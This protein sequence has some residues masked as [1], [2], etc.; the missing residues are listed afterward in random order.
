MRRV[1]LAFGAVLICI[2][3]TCS[4]RGED[5]SQNKSH[6]KNESLRGLL[7]SDCLLLPS[8]HQK[9]NSV[10][11]SFPLTLGQ[12]WKEVASV[13]IW[14]TMLETM[15]RRT[16]VRVRNRES[17]DPFW[18]KKIDL[19]IW[20]GRPKEGWIWVGEVWSTYLFNPWHDP[21]SHQIGAGACTGLNWEIKYPSLHSW[22][23]RS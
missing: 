18:E 6:S 3:T 22:R 23:Q 17:H 7:S 5:Q 2:I 13:A 15:H 11:F 4:L 19:G 8:P 9:C 16:A 14:L 20:P 10:S 21:R 12:A 1:V